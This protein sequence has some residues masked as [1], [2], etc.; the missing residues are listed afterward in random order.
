MTSAACPLCAG[1][2]TALKYAIS[3]Q[4]LKKAWGPY[5][6]NFIQKGIELRDTQLWK[7][8][9]CD[10]EFFSPAQIGTQE[11]YAVLTESVA[12][13]YPD[14]KWEY[15]TAL[16][17]LKKEGSKHVLELGCGDG[18]FLKMLHQSSVTAKGVDFIMSVPQEAKGD[19]IQADLNTFKPSESYEAVVSFQLLEHLE[20]PGLF[21]TNVYEMLYPGGLLILA[22]PNRE[23]VYQFMPESDKGLDLPPHHATRWNR[24]A[25]EWIGKKFHYETLAFI[26]EPLRYDH[27][28]AMMKSQRNFLPPGKRSI[29]AR[30]SAKFIQILQE[31]CMPFH[32]FDI[33]SRVDGHTCLII[34]QK[35]VGTKLS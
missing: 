32:Y 12:A 14:E 4:L 6:E 9:D 3:A 34:F 22:V 16:E 23:G 17:T 7:C 26:T 8:T 30:L 20:K 2:R 33:R 25:L 5:H 27:Y 11:F 1:S 28:C 21:L 15:Q 35:T 19:I 13:Y 31:I 18:S 10:L 29:P 24:A